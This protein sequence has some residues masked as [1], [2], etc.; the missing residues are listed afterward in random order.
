MVVIAR[1]SYW[2][3]SARQERIRSPSTSTVHAPHAP[4]SQPFLVPGRPTSSRSRSSSET[5]G[6][7]GRDTG[8]PLIIMLIGASQSAGHSGAALIYRWPDRGSTRVSGDLPFDPLMT[9]TREFDSA[10]A[11]G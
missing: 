5:R 3:A 6:S 8:T 2:T 4:W 7:F 10:K 9:L 11:H 1:P